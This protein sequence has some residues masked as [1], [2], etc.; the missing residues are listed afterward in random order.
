MIKRSEQK[1]YEYIDTNINEIK[2]QATIVELANAQIKG[3]DIACCNEALLSRY[4]QA[5]DEGSAKLY[6]SLSKLIN[7]LVWIMA[8][9]III[10]IIWW[11]ALE[12][13]LTYCNCT[14]EEIERLQAMVE[15]LEGLFAY[16]L[17]TAL[18]FAGGVCKM[19]LRKFQN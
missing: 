16:V 4:E 1:V 18:G 10:L 6:L 7:L 19:F 8:A 17:T 13:Q 2:S 15:K 3:S 5:C 9:G 12:L 11:L 14:I